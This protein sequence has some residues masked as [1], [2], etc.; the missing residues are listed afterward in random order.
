MYDG[1]FKTGFLN[2]GVPC[3]ERVESQKNTE[4]G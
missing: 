1:R 3:R 4:C 2:Y